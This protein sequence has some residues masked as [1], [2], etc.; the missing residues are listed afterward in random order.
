MPLEN[1]DLFRYDRKRAVVVGCATG[2]GAATAHV[3]QG[4][5]AEVVGVDYKTPTY[6]TASFVEC[7]LRDPEQIASMVKAVGGPIDHLFYCAGL[8][9]TYPP[10]E[11]MRVNLA[12]TR[13]VVEQLHQ[14]MSAGSS[15]SIVSS[16]GGL[17]FMQ[18]LPQIMEL[19]AT[20]GYDSAVSWCKEHSELVADGY[21]FSKEAII[22]YTMKRA[23]E[24]V[25]D[26]IRVNCVSPGPTETPMMPDFERSSSPAIIAAFHGPMGRKA[27]PEEIAWPLAFLNSDAASW[28][29]GFNLVLDGGFLAGV[30]T[31]AIDVG[32]LLASATQG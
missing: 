28:I 31:G 3:V 16:S 26:G 30:M 13:M 10:I 25:G 1:Y 21:V 19:L 12:A 2:M 20:D 11:V 7:D 29:T 23:L 27:K 32:A 22:V 9:P 15:I 14:F 17:Q 8:P 4:L 24:V 18:H 5:G 6:E